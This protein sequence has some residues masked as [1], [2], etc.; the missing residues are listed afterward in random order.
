[1]NRLRTLVQVNLFAVRTL[2]ARSWWGVGVSLALLAL[3][4]WLG[5]QDL[6]G[7]A[8]LSLAAGTAGLA[9]ELWSLWRA[10][11]A[12]SSVVLNR[13][14]DFIR[15]L[16]DEVCP[17]EE[18]LRDGFQVVP[19]QHRPG[20]AVVRSAAVDTWLRANSVAMEEDPCKREE[21]DRLLR[22]HAGMLETVLRCE[23][24]RSSRSVPPR[25]LFNE[26]KLGLTD[27]I[28]PSR[29]TVRVHQVGYFHSLLTNEVATQH[30]ET[31][32]ADPD[33]VFSG[34]RHL[35]PVHADD[36]GVRSLLP[37]AHSR[38]SDHIGVSTLVVTRDR[39]LVFWNQG[40]NAQQS[41]N[42][43]VSTGSGS[44]DWEDRVDADLKATLVA[45]MEREFLEESF[46][47]QAPP[48][49]KRRTRVLGYFRWVSRGAKP[50][51]S[52][53]T[54]IDLD[55]HR[56]S[57]NIAEVNRRDRSRLCR[58]VPTLPH[59]VRVL[60]EL[61]A[62]EQVSVS[63][64]ANMLSLREAVDEDPGGCSDFLGLPIS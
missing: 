3:A 51:F 52:G 17:A 2:Q 32:D 53:V 31:L 29:A 39:K 46:G 28:S 41:R 64:W 57:P 61:L 54:H 62:A 13:E 7:G 25:A 26:R 11:R 5:L 9:R 19:L 48:V 21:V 56:L 43:Y 27:G 59:L 38:M 36:G 47:G 34:S 15:K 42:R 35:F 14:K 8:W 40:T 10:V 45:A 23:A 22:S 60:D 37:V 6:A 49:F 1:M 63:L 33:V 24:R 16:V 20:E 30:L 12:P 18:E 4:V 55:S 58:D 44:C 50:E